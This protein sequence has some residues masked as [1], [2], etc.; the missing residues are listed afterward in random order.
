MVSQ[1]VSVL[2]NSI[3]RGLSQVMAD[4]CQILLRV[5]LAI[6]FPQCNSRVIP[7]MRAVLGPHIMGS[8]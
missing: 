5:V 2:A 3:V 4:G 6:A 7:G 1:A 8:S